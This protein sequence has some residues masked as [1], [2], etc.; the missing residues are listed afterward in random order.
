VAS[1]AA[2]AYLDGLAHCTDAQLHIDASLLVQL[3]DKAGPNFRL[4]AALFC[5]HRVFAGVDVGDYE[6]S[7]FAC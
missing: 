7:G 5:S 4:E 3:Q 2:C 1:S 6:I